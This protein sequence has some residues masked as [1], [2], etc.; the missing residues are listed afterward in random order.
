MSFPGPSKCAIFS[1]VAHFYFQ[2][3]LPNGARK[4]DN[5]SFGEH[6][7]LTTTPTPHLYSNYPKRVRIRSDFGSK[8]GLNAGC[9]NK[10]NSRPPKLLLSKRDSFFH[11]NIPHNQLFSHTWNEDAAQ[12]APMGS[13]G[14]LFMDFATIFEGLC[15]FCQD[16]GAAAGVC[17]GCLFCYSASFVISSAVIAARGTSIMVPTM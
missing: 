11:P 16:F 13:Q 17:W 2:N 12:G 10:H 15:V 9:P 3:D 5:S 7:I 4:L 8:S 1:I 14:R 6:V